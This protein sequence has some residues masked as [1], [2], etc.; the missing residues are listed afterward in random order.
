MNDIVWEN[1]K[2]NIFFN[3]K[4]KNNNHNNNNNSRNIYFEY[5]INTNLNKILNKTIKIQIKECFQ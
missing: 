1:I 2:S 5:I 3:I 4:I